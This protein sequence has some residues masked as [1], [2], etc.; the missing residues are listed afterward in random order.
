MGPTL[1]IE[2]LDYNLRLASPLFYSPSSYSLRQY[3]LRNACLASRTFRAIA[4]PLLREVY[5]VAQPDALD[6]LL[7]LDWGQPGF[8]VTVKLLL[9]TTG[10]QTKTTGRSSRPIVR[11][12]LTS[13]FRGMMP[14]RL[15][16]TVP[17]AHSFDSA[18]PLYEKALSLSIFDDIQ[19][20]ITLLYSTK[21]PDHVG[22]TSVSLPASLHPN[23]IVEPDLALLRDELLE[24]C[25]RCSREGYAREVKEKAEE[26]ARQRGE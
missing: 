15:L 22:L 3:T 6:R 20:I 25:G 18:S 14:P 8:G 26:R 1:P 13:A 11:V 2:L 9:S 16:I 10:T 4:Q 12:W 21:P 24:I 17:E 23:S 19:L 5:V 7:F